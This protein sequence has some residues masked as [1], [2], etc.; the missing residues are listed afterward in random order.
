MTDMNLRAVDRVIRIVRQ[1]DRY[2]G[3]VAACALAPGAALASAGVSRSA[4]P[5]CPGLRQTPP[6]VI[7]AKAGIQ[8]RG[9]DGSRKRDT[10]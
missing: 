8:S 7:P 6:H 9:S 10:P 3:F 1:L 4:P 2:H 5:E